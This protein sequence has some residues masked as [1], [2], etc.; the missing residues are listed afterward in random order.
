LREKGVKCRVV[1]FP[2]WELFEEQSQEYRD[3]VVPKNKFRVYVECAS[4]SFGLERYSDLAICMNSFGMSAPGG[5]NKKHFGFTAEN[6]AK[7]TL[8][9][10]KK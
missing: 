9:A 4:T 3:S 8:E 10:Y 5:Q 7:K 1:S 6:I 2:C